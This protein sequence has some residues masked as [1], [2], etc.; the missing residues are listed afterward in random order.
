[1]RQD[2][3]HPAHGYSAMKRAYQYTFLMC[4][5]F[6]FIIVL[7]SA[8]YE[9]PAISITIIIPSKLIPYYDWF[10]DF[11]GWRNPEQILPA[12]P[13]PVFDSYYSVT[14]DHNSITNLQLPGNRDL[15][16]LQVT[17]QPASGGVFKKW[18][19]HFFEYPLPG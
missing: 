17:T 10:M 7:L 3:A 19:D 9:G 18:W 16:K 1:M 14:P 6:L 4:F 15:L 12:H 8:P 2:L 11:P 13:T 5:I